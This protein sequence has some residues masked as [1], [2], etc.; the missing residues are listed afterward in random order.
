MWAHGS[1]KALE[2][3]VSNGLFKKYKSVQARNTK[4]S[5]RL[6]SALSYLTV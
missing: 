2:K 1:K 3:A 6:T 4:C 5:N